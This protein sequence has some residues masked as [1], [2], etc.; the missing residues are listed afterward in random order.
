MIVANNFL[1][2]TATNA[3][4]NS[5]NNAGFGNNIANGTV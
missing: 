4:V 2:A 1:L 3:V 5:G